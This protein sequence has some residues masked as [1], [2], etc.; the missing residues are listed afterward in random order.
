[1]QQLLEIKLDRALEEIAALKIENRRILA[2]LD[3]LFRQGKALAAQNAETNEKLNRLLELFS[4][5][6]PT[7]N[8]F[9]P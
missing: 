2:G 4:P 3:V 9:S 6:Q 5:K 7:Q 1:M 8:V